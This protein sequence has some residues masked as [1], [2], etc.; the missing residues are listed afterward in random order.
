MNNDYR[1]NIIDHSVMTELHEGKVILNTIRW[2]ARG[3]NPSAMMYEGVMKKS[4]EG[5]EKQKQHNYNHRTSKKGYTNLMEELKAP[6]L[7]PIDRCIVWKQ[8]LMNRKGQFPDE[9]MKEAVNRIVSEE[10][11]I[12]HALG[13]KD[14]PGIVDSV[15][16]YVT[17][18]KYFH[19][20]TQPKTNQKDDE[21]ALSEEQ[22]QMAKRV[23]ELEVELLKMKE[24]DDCVRELKEEP[25]SQKD[26]EDVVELN[27]EINVNIGKENEQLEGKTL[28]KMKVGIPCKLTFEMK[29]H[30]VAWRTI[31][32]SDVEGDNVKVA[33][34]VVVDE[35]CAILIPTKQ[36]IYKMSQRDFSSMRPIAISCLD[37]Y[38]MYLYTLMES[39]KTLNPYKFFDAGSISY[40][41]SKEESAQLLTARLLGT[42][43]DQL[44]LIP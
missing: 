29:E 25:E 38:I 37:A 4:E 44:L 36:G 3:P 22:D 16:K 11:I 2:L 9:E 32:D 43:Y 19:T 21:K 15:G 24:K 5:K 34:D 18:K 17:K 27:E 35:D 14:Q 42:Y 31:F 8:A 6:L 10:D 33:I 28:K 13:G 41:S 12:T 26:I 39:A 30:V 23:K 20:A 40:G 1:L 7:D